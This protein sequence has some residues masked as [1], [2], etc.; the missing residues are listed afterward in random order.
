[1]FKFTIRLDGVRDYERALREAER[2]FDRKVETF[3]RRIAEIGLQTASAEYA[4]A[5]D[6]GEKDVDPVRIDD[7]KIKN[8][9]ISL[10]A[11]GN[12]VLF[13]E[14]GTGVLNP[15]APEARSEL[16]SGAGLYKHGEYGQGRGENPLGW[17]YYGTIHSQ[18]PPGT[19][20]PY[21]S[22]LANKGLVHTYG[23]AAQPFMYHAK[24]RM[25]EAVPRIF[26]EV[27]NND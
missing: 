5:Y 1:M 14:F 11:E 22:R 15:D 2:K 8:G 19:A 24:K 9:I 12:S 13:I 21:D 18:V 17:Y 6:A 10:V 7:S 4:V 26:Q 3:L 20:Y 23:Q 25:E 27:F 16:E